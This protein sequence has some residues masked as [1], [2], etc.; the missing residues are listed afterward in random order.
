MSYE[1]CAQFICKVAH[2]IDFQ[3]YL[4]SFTLISRNFGW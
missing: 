2:V 4:K 3:I 1:I